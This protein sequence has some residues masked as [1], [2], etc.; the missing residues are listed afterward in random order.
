MKD[1]DDFEG[2]YDEFLG[3]KARLKDLEDEFQSISDIKAVKLQH[4][5]EMHSFNRMEENAI[6]VHRKL[7]HEVIRSI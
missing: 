4:D 1:L 5:F 7:I 6:E 2:L 3:T